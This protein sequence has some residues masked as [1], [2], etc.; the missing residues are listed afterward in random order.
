MKKYK[1]NKCGMPCILMFEGAIYPPGTCPF[2][3]RTEPIWQEKEVKKLNWKKAKAE[4][5]F[6]LKNK[7][8]ADG[9]KRGLSD[10]MLIINNNI[11]EE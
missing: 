5:E 8:A 1:C 3:P 10:A 6:R 7:I 11:T 2:N 9:Y 4:I